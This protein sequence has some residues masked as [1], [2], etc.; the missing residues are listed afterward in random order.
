MP[1][2]LLTDLDGTLLTSDAQLSDY[3]VRVINNALENGDCISFATA[4]SY[5][6]SM[7]VTSRI[8][9]RYPLVLYNGSLLFDPV[10]R[11]VLG[12]HWLA[13]ET[14][15]A[16][17]ALGR[18]MALVPLLFALD[19]TDRER[20]LHERLT[21]EGDQRF[22]ASRPG[23]P[24]FTEVE[25]LSCLPSYRTLIVTYIGLR[26]ELEPLFHAITGRYGAAV[27]V[28]F[29]RDTYIDN[30]YF[31][32]VS[33]PLANKEHGMRLWCEHVGCLPEDVTVFGDNL[34][35]IG[36]FKRAGTRLAVSGAHREL[37]LMA[38]RIIGSNDEDGVAKEIEALYL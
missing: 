3:T 27:H 38:S 30:H 36:L 23:D 9:W 20:V 35:D 11:Q 28:H 10:N 21:R 32:E 31:L 6:S 8:L 22:Y 25:Q 24:R 4:R 29:M 13:N 7:A 34:N 2:Y 37:K 14:T 15:N 1:R 18:E 12:G 26:E 33:H 19:D 5:Q 17:I 16:I